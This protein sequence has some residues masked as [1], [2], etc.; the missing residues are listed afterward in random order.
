MERIPSPNTNNNTPD[1]T[2]TADHIFV[3]IL[4]EMHWDKEVSITIWKSSVERR[5]CQ[6]PAFLAPAQIIFSSFNT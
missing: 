6:A 2:K 1:Q 4:P 5:P 3:K